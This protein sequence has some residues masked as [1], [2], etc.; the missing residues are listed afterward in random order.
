M[1]WLILFVLLLASI[2]GAPMW[3]WHEY[4]WF[5]SGVGTLLFI[6]VLVLLLRGR[7]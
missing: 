7:V 6:I 4:G 5:P 2:G 1:L 3:G